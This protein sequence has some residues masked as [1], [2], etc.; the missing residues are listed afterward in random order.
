MPKY[1]CKL[2]NA[3]GREA[4]HVVVSPTSRVNDVAGAVANAFNYSKPVIVQLSRDV[5]GAFVMYTGD[6]HVHPN[7]HIMA[8]FLATGRR[9][10]TLVGGGVR[11]I[12]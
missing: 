3:N 5:G 4:P 9:P 11:Y 1:P 6:E 10:G 12:I 8:R 7:T 2:R